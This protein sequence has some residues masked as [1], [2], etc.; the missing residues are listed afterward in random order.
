LVG[1]GKTI[2][3]NRGLPETQY[4]ARAKATWGRSLAQLQPLKR[5]D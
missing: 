5:D 2:S 1:N 3:H 4:T